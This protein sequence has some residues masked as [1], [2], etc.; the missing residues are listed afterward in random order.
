MKQWNSLAI[1]ML[2]LLSLL[3]AGCDQFGLGLTSIGDIESASAAYEGKEVTVR[4]VSSQA[5][6]IPFVGT[7]MYRL[8]DASGEIVVWSNAPTPPE[9]EELIVRGLV[10]NALIVDGR[11]FGLALREQE[12]K[13]VWFKK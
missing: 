2:C 10:E 13:S 4:G 9:G 11:G 7:R 6:K 1:L 3:L 8:K 5:V 12:R